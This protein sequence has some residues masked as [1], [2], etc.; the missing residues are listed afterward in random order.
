MKLKQ[1]RANADLYCEGA[2][3]L[4][5]YNAQIIDNNNTVIGEVVGHKVNI[6]RALENIEDNNG[7]DYFFEADC[8]SQLLANCTSYVLYEL[9][10]T[11]LKRT[12]TI[13]YLNRISIFEE[14]KTTLIHDKVLDLLIEQ[15][16]V[17]LYTFGSTELNDEFPENDKGDYKE[18]EKY[19]LNGNWTKE[20]KYG[21]FSNSTDHLTTEISPEEEVTKN[22]FEILIDE[23]NIHYFMYTLD[24]IRTASE[25]LLTDYFSYHNKDKRLLNEYACTASLSTEKIEELQSINLKEDSYYLS[26]NNILINAYLLHYYDFVEMI[27]PK[28]VSFIQFTNKSIMKNINNCIEKYASLFYG[29]DMFY[30]LHEYCLPD[31]EYSILGINKI[32]LNDYFRSL[33]EDKEFNSVNQLM[34]VVKSEHDKLN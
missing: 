28:S 23:S 2:Y 33:T 26:F 1:K 13:L 16:G 14:K 20:Y 12:P 34:E 10:Q 9:P 25:G 22:V 17:V 15:N 8:M 6:F 4:C 19:L 29:K 7:A 24:F 5:P 18:Y 31:Y 27:N 11:L 3:Y 30:E 32:I 21:L